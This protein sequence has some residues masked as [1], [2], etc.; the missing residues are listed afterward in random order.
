MTT[1][2]NAIEQM[3]A[4]G[5]PAFPPGHP[6]VNTGK[7]IR[8]GPKKKAWYRLHEFRSNISNQYVVGGSFGVWGE[9]PA[10]SIEIDWKGI[11]AEERERLQKQRQDLEAKEKAKREERARN[12]ASRAITQWKGATSTKPD[13][14]ETYLDRKGVT[15]VKGIRYFKKDGT[16]LVPMIRYDITEEQEAAPG[17]TGPRRL[18]GL[19]KIAPDGSKLFNKGMSKEGAMC[20]LGNAPK[21]GDLVLVV[22]GIAT[23][24]SIAMAIDNQFPIFVAFDAGNLLPAAR[25]LRKLY[26]ENPILFCADDDAYLEASLNKLLRENYRL[27]ELV[28]PPVTNWKY[29]GQIRDGDKWSAVELVVSAERLVDDAGIPAIVGSVQAGGR[30]FNFTRENAG[31]KFAS[32]AAAEIGNASVIYPVFAD[33]KLP[34]D[35]DV[36]KLT[37][38]N[39]LHKIEGLDAVRRQLAPELDRVRLSMEVARQVKEQLAKRKGGKGNDGEPPQPPKDK[40]TNDFWPKFYR[41]FTLIYPTQTAWDED[42]DEIVRVDAMRLNFG[43]AVIKWWLA[44]DHRRTVNAQDVVFDPSEKCDPKSTI[45]LFRGMQFKPKK[46]DCKKLLKM[47]AYLCGEEGLEQTPITNHVLKWI[48]YPLQ[49]PGAKMQTAIV[50]FGA[51]GTG[52]NMFWGAIL[53]IY[54]RYGRLINQFQ[55]ES[56]FNDWVSRA[57]FV[58]ANEV[59]TSLERRH[60]VGYLKNLVTEKRIPIE[61]K[62][63]PVREEDNHMQLV[64]LSNELQPLHISPGDRRYQV[65]RTPGP[66]GPEY[67]EELE[68]E[69]RN[70]GAAALYQYLLELDL[71]DFNAHTKPIDTAG[72]DLVIELGL[73]SA[74]AF[75]RDLHDGLLDVPYCPAEG[76]DL[77]RLY[78][79]YCDRTGVKHPAPMPAFSHKFMSMNGVTRRRKYRMPEKASD[80]TIAS[81]KW[82][83]RVV[84]VMGDPASGVDV[85]TWIQNGVRDFRDAARSYA[86]LNPWAGGSS[87]NPDDDEREAARA[88][89]RRDDDVAF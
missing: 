7:I 67:Y 24:L 59:V 73:D 63:L 74:Q 6:A 23:G 5:M 10:T 71:G 78:R 9:I 13:G 53:S 52:K 84:F 17:Y 14:I 15:H 40:A 8:Y 45:N 80:L 88:R 43:D 62:Q 42:L 32:K 79:I 1:L 37:D 47:I 89:S 4:A 50:M 11:A 85:D 35:P 82:P 49:H 48:A 86:R 44:S 65:I 33:R 30:S 51:E 2:A 21:R 75:W 83:Q 87:S 3:L 55:L 66:K 64:F 26:P 68:L 19:Q 57:M 38:F 39:D 41:R 58:V 12:A 61:T 31:R 77:Y 56:R 34:P 22:E 28:T 54:G 81:N 69:I 27:A 36:S 72:K 20:R 70:G 25:I 76:N 46:G 60:L 18:L 29:Q 16:V